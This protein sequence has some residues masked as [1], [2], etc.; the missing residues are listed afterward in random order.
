[1]SFYAR[2]K[3]N[4]EGKLSREE[5]D[6][7][8]RGYQIVGKILLIRLKP[9]LLKRRALIGRTILKMLPYIHIVVLLKGIADVERKPRIEVIA[10]SGKDHLAPATQTLHREHGCVFLLDLADVMWAAG[11]KTE[12]LRLLKL[13]RPREVIVDMFAGIGYWCIPI[14]KYRRP[15]RIY[16]IDINPVATEYLRKN[17]WMNG[18]EDKIE[19]LLGDCRH[20][21]KPLAGVADRIIMGWLHGTERYLPVA[22]EV[23]KPLAIIHMHRALRAEKTGQ[24]KRKIISIGERKH[25]K[26][27]VLDIKRVKSYA[28]GIDHVVF[29]LAIKKLKFFAGQNYL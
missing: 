2:L 22:L 21:A 26:I 17:A 28:P 8:P 24:L 7:L 14:A 27:R 18:V 4:L 15:K 1:M 6:L 13:V 9:R 25:S 19:I 10:E 20:F 29:D 23:A 3:K 11:N 16:A 12:K 5:L